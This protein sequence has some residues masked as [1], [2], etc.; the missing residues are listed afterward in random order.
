MN[1]SEVARFQH[2]MDGSNGDVYVRRAEVVAVTPDWTEDGIGMAFARL[3][4][5]GGSS[6]I[7]RG[8]ADDVAA[9]LFEKGEPR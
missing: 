7:V 1:A 6:V 5:R 2:P 4:L 9:A 8:D 3:H